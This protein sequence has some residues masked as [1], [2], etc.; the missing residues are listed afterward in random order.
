MGFWINRKHRYFLSNRAITF[1]FFLSLLSVAMADTFLEE[2]Q[3][4]LDSII[5]GMGF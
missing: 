1:I 4:K 3:T 5:N 2:L